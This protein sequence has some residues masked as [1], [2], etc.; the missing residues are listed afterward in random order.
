MLNQKTLRKQKTKNTI[1][2]DS[3]L[4]PPKSEESENQK[5]LGK[6]NQK[7]NNSQRLLAGP[8]FPK[9]FPRIVFFFVF[10]WFS[11]G[12]SVFLYFGG[13]SQESPR[14]VFLLFC[15]PKVF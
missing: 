1:L 7:K 13:S 2:R 9:D 14:N 8:P 6:T 5:N 3:C 11:Q 4:D 12:F 15:F 10:F